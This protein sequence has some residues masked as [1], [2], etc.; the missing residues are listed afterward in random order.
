M[1]VA[2][3]KKYQLQIIAGL[4]LIVSILTLLLFN[5]TG[6]E[7]DSI[8][9]YLFARYAPDHPELFLNHWA[10]PLFTL[11]ASPFAQFGFI[12]VKVLNGF[13]GL[14]SVIFTFKIAQQFKLKHAILAPLFY[15][16]FPLSF[17]VNYS[18]FTEP[19]FAAMLCIS[20][21]CCLKNKLAVA[22]IIVS[23]M[24]F[25]RS[26]GLLFI[27]LFGLYFML[28]K[29]YRCI[30][31]LLIGHLIF[32][33]VGFFFGESPLWVATKIPYASLQ[34]HYGSGELIHFAEQLIYMTGVP[35]IIFLLLG[36]I[37]SIA[38]KKWIVPHHKLTFSTLLVGGFLLFFI[39]HS[40]FWYLG[41]FNSMGLKRVFGAITPLMAIL[42]LI[43]FNLL[44]KIRSNGLK[45][46][47]QLL[48]LGYIF[49]FP[50]TSN[51]A[52]IDWKKDMNLSK[53]Q[54]TAENAADYILSS[55]TLKNK[56]FIY[57]DPYLG[58]ALKID[59]FD[60]EQQL[61]LSP[62]VFSELR[63]GDVIIW[64]NWHSV[65]DYGVELSL[66]EQHHGLRKLKQFDN[67]GVKYVVWIMNK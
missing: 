40:L 3:L 32:A 54:Q 28:S 16:I 58:H 26:E 21:Y 41:I 9:H 33:A 22:A 50:F 2:S 42:A 47:L 27:G 38:F 61:I 67:N 14:I 7:A 49:I 18:G 53:A 10:K 30:F 64:D 1:Q 37:R 43:G 31:Y 60:I 59:P 45:K 65:I 13:M 52:A 25:V 46:T 23:F 56:R 11:L 19:L 15:F 35:L 51:P 55:D 36:L 63:K 17:L 12:G 66:L 24:P 4:Y 62:Q 34:S 8:N 57:T 29:K 20:I 39:A 48:I 44:D 5:G 6:G